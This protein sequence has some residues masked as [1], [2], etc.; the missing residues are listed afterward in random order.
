M[1]LMNRVLGPTLVEKVSTVLRAHRESRDCSC[2][3]SGRQVSKGIK[4]VLN[5][6]YGA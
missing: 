3:G 4:M 5:S 2:P 6:L 1:G